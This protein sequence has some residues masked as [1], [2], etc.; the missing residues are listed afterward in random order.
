[1]KYFEQKKSLVSTEDEV[2]TDSNVESKI[3]FW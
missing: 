2:R 3:D 1:M